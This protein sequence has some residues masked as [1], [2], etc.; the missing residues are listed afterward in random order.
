MTALWERDGGQI[1]MEGYFWEETRRE[2]RD[3]LPPTSWKVW[4]GL[5]MKN[6]IDVRG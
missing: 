6:R 3:Y 5:L 2:D 4:C 1:E